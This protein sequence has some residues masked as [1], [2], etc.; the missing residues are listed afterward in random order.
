MEKKVKKI[1]RKKKKEKASNINDANAILNV[2]ESESS[3]NFKIIKSHE[4]K[5]KINSIEEKNTS[6]TVQE[7][8]KKTK[9]ENKK[10]KPLKNYTVMDEKKT[11]PVKK[12]LETEILCAFKKQKKISDLK[13]N[14][15]AK[16]NICDYTAK[17]TKMRNDANNFFDIE[18]YRAMNRLKKIIRYFAF[19]QDYI[20]NLINTSEIIS[21]IDDSDAP[22]CMTCGQYFTII[23]RR[24]HCRL[25]GILMCANCSFFIYKEALN[26][27]IPKYEVFTDIKVSAFTSENV[28]YPLHRRDSGISSIADKDSDPLEVINLLSDNFEI[29]TCRHCFQ[30]LFNQRWIH[31][32]CMD[33]SFLTLCNKQKTL[34]SFENSTCQ[35][36][37]D[38]NKILSKKEKLNVFEIEKLNILMVDIYEKFSY[39]DTFS[40]EIEKD[41]PLINT[42]N[43]KKMEKLIKMLRY[44]TRNFILD[45]SLC[46]EDINV[47]YKQNKELEIVL[48]SDERN[49]P[50]IKKEDSI[51]IDKVVAE[52][53]ILEKVKDKDSHHRN[54]FKVI[55]K[56]KKKL[57][58]KYEKDEKEDIF[59]D[60]RTSFVILE[61]I[62]K[63]E[64]YLDQAI[65]DNNVY[66]VDILQNNINDL[67]K[68]LEKSK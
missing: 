22:I 62:A 44:K 60:D 18:Q 59:I 26:E 29:R 35:I 66:Q 47:E 64:E 25:C 24:H 14:E 27:I 17:F 50:F 33:E 20:S 4:E 3:N 8:Y 46:V 36:L 10:K 49:N 45:C 2:F 52:G 5:I 65:K 43:S 38:M 12:A 37:I 34:R 1:F 58:K 61:Q 13:V 6:S 56:T 63:L 51:D 67:N 15:N 19:Q 16:L 57:K 55:G 11:K 68:I 41:G 31:K 21:W 9:K 40:K 39:L 48:S 53:V 23:L 54:I 30:I 28:M 7:I 32:D 42:S